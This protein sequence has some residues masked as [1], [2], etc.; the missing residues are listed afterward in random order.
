MITEK[1]TQQIWILLSESFPTVVSKVSQPFWFIGKLMFCVCVP[2]REAHKWKPQQIKN[3]F[4]YRTVPTSEKHSSE[5]F[6]RLSS[7]VIHLVDWPPCPKYQMAV[8]RTAFDQRIVPYLRIKK[9]VLQSQ[10]PKWSGVIQ[11]TI[12][13]GFWCIIRAVFA[14]R[15]GNTWYTEHERYDYT[16]RHTCKQ[17]LRNN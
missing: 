10:H 17:T 15:S 16:R 2:S 1:W 8:S 5:T 6:K 9:L 13:H 3:S 12:L 7:V 14:R 11:Y 4:N